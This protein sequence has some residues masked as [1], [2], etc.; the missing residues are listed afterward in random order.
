MTMITIIIVAVAVQIICEMV[1]VHIF[2]VKVSA[3]V[4]NIDS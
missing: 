4:H 3:Y 2:E 1:L